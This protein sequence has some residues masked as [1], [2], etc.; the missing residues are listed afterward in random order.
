MNPILSSEFRK[1]FSKLTKSVSIELKTIFVFDFKSKTILHIGQIYIT[2][3]VIPKFWTPS[4]YDQLSTS[5]HP[6]LNRFLL[7]ELGSS[8]FNL[9]MILRLTDIGTVDK[10]QLVNKIDIIE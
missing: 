2:S 8:E 7:R 3:Y 5:Y 9:V 10:L 1:F 4:I 6:K